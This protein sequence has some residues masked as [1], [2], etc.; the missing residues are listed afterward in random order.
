MSKSGYPVCIDISEDGILLAVS[1]LFVD[2]GVLSTSVAY[3]NFGAVGQNEVDN[4]VSGYNYPGTVVPYVCFIN[5]NTS[6]VLGD[7]SFSIF[8][9]SEKPESIFEKDID[10]EVLSVFADEDMIVLVFE[11]EEGENK[12][13]AQ[14]YESYLPHALHFPSTV[15]LWQGMVFVYLSRQIEQV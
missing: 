2:N 4:L 1:Y 3:Y 14:V 8:K 7:N 15:L 9:G 11:D 12:F 10:K 5:P 13:I 6:F